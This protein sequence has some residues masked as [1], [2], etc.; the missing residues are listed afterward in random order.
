MIGN[1]RPR[2]F[3]IGL[4]YPDGTIWIT[5]EDDPNY[6]TDTSNGEFVSSVY[7]G[8]QVAASYEARRWTAIPPPRDPSTGPCDPARTGRLGQDRAMVPGAPTSVIACTVGRTTTLTAETS[9][10][11]AASRSL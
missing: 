6:C 5:T 10:P 4:S 11:L 1:L 2:T 3:A 7:V 8:D 9:M